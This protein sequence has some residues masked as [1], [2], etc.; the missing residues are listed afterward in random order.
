MWSPGSNPTPPKRLN[1]RRPAC[2]RREN[3]GQPCPRQRGPAPRRA[4]LRPQVNPGTI[5]RHAP[6]SAVGTAERPEPGQHAF[7]LGA[8]RETGDC[9]LAAPSSKPSQIIHPWNV[10][11]SAGRVA[12][13]SGG[14]ATTCAR[15]A[16]AREERLARRQLGQPR[17]MPLLQVAQGA[18]AP[19]KAPERTG[20]GG[21]IWFDR[22]PVF[23]DALDRVASSTFLLRDSRAAN[24]PS[25]PNPTS[26]R[27][28]FEAGG[29]YR[30]R[31]CR[32]R[33]VDGLVP[34]AEDHGYSCLPWL[35][36]SSTGSGDPV[37]RA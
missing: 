9:T 35:A 8:A 32:N 7:D 15:D 21:T 5:K 34:L 6:Y 2:P 3:P 37:A 1:E 30:H 24:S 28:L 11:P 31:S 36:T 27:R 22:P 16:S 25:F 19:G 12:R 23:G 18:E 26:S 14:Q 33:H 20:T 13:P 17:P 29:R 4:C 10:R